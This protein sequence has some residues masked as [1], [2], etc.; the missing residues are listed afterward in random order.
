M[1]GEENSNNRKNLIYLIKREDICA[2][3]FKGCEGAKNKELFEKT[4]SQEYNN[5]LK[6]A[7]YN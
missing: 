4:C 3:A 7:E 6:L 2:M 1:T 5:C